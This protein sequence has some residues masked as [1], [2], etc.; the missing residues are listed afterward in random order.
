VEIDRD[1]ERLTGCLQCNRWQSS[2]HAFVVELSAKELKALREKVG[3]REK[4]D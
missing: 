2:K 4:P 1:G 3:L